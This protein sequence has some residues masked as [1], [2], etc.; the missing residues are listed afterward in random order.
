MSK[1]KVKEPES[2]VNL[3]LTLPSHFL[4]M[5]LNLLSKEKLLKLQKTVNDYCKYW[6][7]K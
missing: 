7:V 1:K 6:N 3:E 5:R 2:E 4:V